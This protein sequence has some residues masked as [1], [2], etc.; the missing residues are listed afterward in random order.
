MPL[1]P[2]PPLCTIFLE[3]LKTGGAIEAGLVG[4]LGISVRR[5]LVI[6]GCL[7][8]AV[9][10]RHSGTHIDDGRDAVSRGEPDIERF[11]DEAVG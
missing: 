2:L 9:Q 4:D 7:G 10:R 5:S 3:G 6:A 1:L 8:V 11:A